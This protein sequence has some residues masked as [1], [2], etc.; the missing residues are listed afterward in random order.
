M[1]TNKIKFRKIIIALIVLTMILVPTLTVYA[2]SINT[3]S[4]I[5]EFS[6]KADKSEKEKSN[7]GNDDNNGKSDEANQKDNN[8]KT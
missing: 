1:N 2:G 4:A 7:N 3:N 8:G 6:F 5:E